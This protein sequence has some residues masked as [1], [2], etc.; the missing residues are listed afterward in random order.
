MAD[1]NVTAA[2][3][4]FC[5][6]SGLLFFSRKRKLALQNRKKRV[7]VFCGSRSGNRPEYAEQARALGK[8]L[9]EN[10][11]E[12]VY[13]GGNI[14]L[15]G[16]LARA[17]DEG[18]GAVYSVIPRALVPF[19]G[20]II[21][22]ERCTVTG[23]MHERKRKFV[24]LSDAFISLPGGLGTFEELCET[25]T[26][27]QLGVH[28]K[29]FGV[30]NICGFF[31]PLRSVFETAI[32]EGFLG[33]EWRDGGI[34]FDN[35]VDELIKKIITKIHRDDEASKALISSHEWII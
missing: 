24:E 18:G 6:L 9:V 30:L 17:V 31:D 14:G 3:I 8:A 5:A 28:F 16:E 20:R 11:I 21:Q 1:K 29:P 27:R 4:G 22:P 33:K 19:T 2:L 13:G 32:T 23:G 34:I 15:M 7:C 25:A 26:W 12:L 35:N 10:D